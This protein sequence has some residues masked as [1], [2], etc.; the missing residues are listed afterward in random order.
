[1]K[2]S[3]F[4]EMLYFHILVQILVDFDKLYQILV[5][6]LTIWI[7]IFILEHLKIPGILEVDSQ[8][9]KNLCI[10]KS[11]FSSKARFKMVNKFSNYD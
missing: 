5:Q 9:S 2:N 7:F 11:D 1:M 8:I 6:I 10:Q 4:S 3:V